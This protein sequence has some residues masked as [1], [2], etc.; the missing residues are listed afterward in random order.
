MLCYCTF[1]PQLCVVRLQSNCL[2]PLFTGWEILYFLAAINS[3]HCSCSGTETLQH[4]IF[5]AS[6][7]LCINPNFLNQLHALYI[8]RLGMQTQFYFPLYYIS[9]PYSPA[10]SWWITIANTHVMLLY[11]LSPTL[12]CLST[13]PSVSCHLW[14]AGTFSTF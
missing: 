10:S 6:F 11:L 13:S 1:S 2:L 12:C 3:P 8:I 4:S 9:N 5:I 14:L 7:Y